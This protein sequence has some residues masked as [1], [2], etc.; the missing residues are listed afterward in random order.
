MPLQV[1]KC[2]WKELDL[3]NVHG[4]TSVYYSQLIINILPPQLSPSHYTVLVYMICFA[5]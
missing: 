1:S 4:Q 5:M 3:N 2:L